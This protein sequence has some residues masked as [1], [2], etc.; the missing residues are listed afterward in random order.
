MTKFIGKLTR[1]GYKIN[2]KKLTDNQLESIINDLTVTPKVNESFGEEAK[3]Y[4]VYHE[5]DKYITVPRYYG[6]IHFGR[7]QISKDMKGDKVDLKFLGDLRD[8]QKPIIDASL[9]HMKTFGGGLLQLHCGAGKTVLALYLACALNV[10]TLIIVHKSFLQN[11]WYERIQE[12]T[13]AR[14]GIIRQ[15]KKD[16]ENK[17]IV[18]GMLQ[19]I[20]QIDYDLEIF[21]GFELIIVDECHHIASRVFSRALYKTGCKYTLGLSATPKR[22]DGL[23]K[24][25]NWYLGDIMYKLERK[26]VNNVNIKVFNYHTTNNKFKEA[27]RW[28]K[29]QG[30]KPHIPIMITN[31]SE[32]DERNDLILNIINLLREQE[33]RKLLILSGRIKHLEFLK[34]NTDNL[35]KQLELTGDLEEDECTTSFYIGR[36]KEYELQDSAKADIIFASYEMAE[37]GLDIPTLNTLILATPPRNQK[38]LI[39]C[40]GRIMRKRMEDCEVSPLVIDLIDK[41]SSFIGQGYSR[42]KYY[43]KKDY[44]V[45]K[46]NIIKNSLVTKDD[47]ILETVGSEKFDM[48]NELKEIGEYEDSDD[49]YELDLQNVLTVYEE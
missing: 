46:Y 9:K 38:T 17:D 13:N 40:I 39:Q 16:V 36:M 29:N 47:F 5:D 21:K 32:I 34:Y 43:N 33:E 2:K 44:T 3:S 10:K 28:V 45:C 6:F 1:Q 19:S 4:E 18:V 8:S 24:V 27:R 20:S 25:I 35:I 31:I 37:E 23:T 49:E 41:F 42:L 48:I 7:P 15:K 11:Q 30:K 14:I 12:F 26:G 22:S